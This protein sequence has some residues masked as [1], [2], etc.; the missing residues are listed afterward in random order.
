MYLPQA[1]SS[2]LVVRQLPD[3]TLVFD[4][5]RNKA[6]C[7]NRTVAL[8]FSAIATAH[9]PLPRLAAILQ[10]QLNV[11]DAEALLV[12]LAVVAASADGNLLAALAWA[13]HKPADAR[14][15]RRAT[16]KKLAVAAVTLP[17]IMTITAKCVAVTSF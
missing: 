16:L 12:H 4:L 8:I 10:D 7:L 1:R 5:Q 14:S 9:G 17:L 11:G 15:S 2:Q 3:E 6:H 13:G